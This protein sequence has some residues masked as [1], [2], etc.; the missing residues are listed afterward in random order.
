MHKKFWIKKVI[1]FTLIAFACL[2]GLAWVVML[3]WNNVL[4]EVVSVS[5]VTYWQALGLLIL[6]KILFGGFR[7]KG[8]D[9]KRKWKEKMEHKLSGL[10]ETEREKIKEEWRQ[11]CSMWKRSGV[12]TDTKAE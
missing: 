3:L 2:A 5:A 11:R 9:Y 6:S 12:D 4:I 7:G 8:G 10:S 1:G